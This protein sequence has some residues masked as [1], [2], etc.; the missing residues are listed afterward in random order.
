MNISFIKKSLLLIIV[1][2]VSAGILYAADVI[3][4]EESDK[5]DGIEVDLKS[6]K[7]KN[8]IITLIL[9]D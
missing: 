7:V 5:W 1:I 2:L 8:N 9:T 6:I 3:Q 4:T